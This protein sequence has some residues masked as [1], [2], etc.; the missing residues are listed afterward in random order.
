MEIINQTVEDYYPC[1]PCY[2]CGYFC[3]FTTLGLSLLFPEPCT[4]QLETN[5]EIVLKRLNNRE[6]LLYRGLIWKFRRDKRS[7]ASWLEICQI[8]YE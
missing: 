2:A 5:L 4:K 7:R 6:E 3:C 8:I 1:L